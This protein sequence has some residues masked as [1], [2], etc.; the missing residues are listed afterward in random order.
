[1]VMPVMRDEGMKFAKLLAPLRELRDALEFRWTKRTYRRCYPFEDGS[2]YMCGF[3][4]ES[5]EPKRWQKL[6]LRLLSVLRHAPEG[7]PNRCPVTG[8]R[9]SLP[10]EVRQAFREVESPDPEVARALEQIG[11]RFGV[12]VDQVQLPRDRPGGSEGSKPGYLNNG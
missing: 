1:M 8:A 3:D 6:V 4:V 5:I 11:R 12:A 7:N 9:Y 2:G 10:V